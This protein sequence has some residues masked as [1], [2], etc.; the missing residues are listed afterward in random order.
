MKNIIEEIFRVQ[1]KLHCPYS[2]FNYFIKYQLN[3][4]KIKEL[5][6]FYFDERNNFDDI[7]NVFY[8]IFYKNE[9]I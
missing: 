3:V 8:N 4:I 7:S 5:F 6:D 9:K 1:T 2:T